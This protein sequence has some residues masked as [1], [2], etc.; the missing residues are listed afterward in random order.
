MAKRA[1]RVLP[2]RK[3]PRDDDSLL[4]RSAESL[5]RVIG[6]LQR[7]VQGTSKRVSS[8]TDKAM[9]AIPDLPR[10]ENPFGRGTRTSTTRQ[11]SGAGKSGTRKSTGGRKRAASRKRA[12]SRSAAKKR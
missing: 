7:Q 12:T 10:M 4:I 8:M 6:S 2:A 1:R 11:S 3:A 5:G 9:D